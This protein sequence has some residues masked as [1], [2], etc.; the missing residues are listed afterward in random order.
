MSR[1]PP[2]GDVPEV[3][4]MA[5][6]NPADLAADAFICPKANS[7]EIVSKVILRK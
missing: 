3:R 2:L 6:K 7:N 5:P 1:V 4:L